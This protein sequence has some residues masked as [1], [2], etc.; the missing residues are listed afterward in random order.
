MP[1]K[2]APAP[3]PPPESPPPEP[4]PPMTNISTSVDD[5]AAIAKLSLLVNLCTFLLPTIKE[6]P[7][8]AVISGGA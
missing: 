2:T 4:P 6:E 7:P 8:V 5:P 1:Y 3:P